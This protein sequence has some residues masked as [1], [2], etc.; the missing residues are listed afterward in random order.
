[1]NSNGLHVSIPT[2]ILPLQC[3]FTLDTPP[4]TPSSTPPPR[5]FGE[6]MPCPRTPRKSLAPRR[7]MDKSTVTSGAVL[8]FE[9]KSRLNRGQTPTLCIA[10]KCVKKNLFRN[11][12]RRENTWEVELPIKKRRLDA[13]EANHCN[14]MLRGRGVEDEA[15]E[16]SESSEEGVPYANSVDVSTSAINDCVPT[17]PK[18]KKRI[19]HQDSDSSKVGTKGK[20]CVSCKTKKTPLWRDAEDGTPYCNACGIRFKKYRIR[21]PL[22]Q[23]IPHKEESL[24]NICSFCSCPLMHCKV[25]NR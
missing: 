4:T 24:R 2:N 11:R 9:F 19:N 6:Y 25:R 10:A 7:S 21:C 3:T 22:C 23:Y 16:D 17:P 20:T 8:R 12:A 18:V 13:S 14:A 5:V 15:D 1:M